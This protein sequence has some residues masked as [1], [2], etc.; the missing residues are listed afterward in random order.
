MSN[1]GC[2][3]QV[4]ASSKWQETFPVLR[5]KLATYASLLGYRH[6]ARDR[7]GE[8]SRRVALGGE[9]TRNARDGY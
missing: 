5:A 3:A 7:L 4:R 8:R 2:G 1:A 6:H 9:R